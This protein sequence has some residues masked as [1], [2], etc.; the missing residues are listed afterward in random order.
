MIIPSV[1]SGVS[2]GS[3]ALNEAAMKAL[4]VGCLVT[5]LLGCVS[6]ASSVDAEGYRYVQG[7]PWRGVKLV[8]QPLRTSSTLCYRYQCYRLNGPVNLPLSLRQ[9][10]LIFDLNFRTLAVAPGIVQR[11]SELMLPEDIGVF[12]FYE[13]RRRHQREMRDDRS[14]LWWVH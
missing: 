4:I 3:Y 13:A 10:Y 6:T 14:K 7:E 12:L 1:F 5:L 8:D 2:V 11:G 9:K